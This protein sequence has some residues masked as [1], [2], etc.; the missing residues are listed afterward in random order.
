MRKNFLYVLTILGLVVSLSSCRSAAPRLDYKALARASVRLG[1][2]IRLED[3]HKLYIEAAEW[4]GVPYRTGGES[5]RGTDC[6]GLTCQIYKKVYHT[7]LSRNT[8]GQKKESSKVAKRNLREGDLVFFTSS[9]SGR[10][11]AHVGIYLKDGKFI[12]AS[13]S[14]GVIVSRLDEPYYTKHWISGGRQR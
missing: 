10:K 3:N 14:Q 9:R 1:V 11:V 6:S 13:T 2:D 8:E 4:M 5:K 12:H 7:K